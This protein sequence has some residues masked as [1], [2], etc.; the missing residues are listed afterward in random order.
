MNSPAAQTMQAETP[1]PPAL[2]DD[3]EGEG[4]ASDSKRLRQTNCDLAKSKA[5]PKSCD[6]VPGPHLKRRAAQKGWGQS[7]R[8]V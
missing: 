3:A 7:A 1:A 8:T 4:K 5:E 6:A 2:L